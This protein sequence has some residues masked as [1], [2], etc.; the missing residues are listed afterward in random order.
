MIFSVSEKNDFVG[1]LRLFV[2]FKKKW[3]RLTGE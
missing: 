1:Q 2:L 3:F